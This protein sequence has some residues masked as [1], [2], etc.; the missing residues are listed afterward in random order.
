MKV[1]V[2]EDDIIWQTRIEMMAA[3]IGL[4]IVGA[5]DSVQKSREFLLAHTPDLIISDIMLGE[6]KVFSLFDDGL[7]TGIPVLFLTQ[8]VNPGNYK[9]A[10]HIKNSHFLVKPFHT[11]SLRAAVDILM[12]PF[13][14]ESTETTGIE[15]KGRFNEKILLKPSQIVY[16]QQSRNYC[17]LK[18]VDKKYALRNSLGSIQKLLG[19]DFVQ[20][21][22]SYVV[23]RYFITGLSANKACLNINEENIAVGRKFREDVL[24]SI[25]GSDWL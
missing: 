5:G 3:E 21:S 11:L 14:G 6:E 4:A 16:V 13:A 25:T 9:Q 23:N 15:V 24:K 1:F 8:S 20:V 7:F 22:K 2:I 17:F 10:R 19:K 18:T 12:K